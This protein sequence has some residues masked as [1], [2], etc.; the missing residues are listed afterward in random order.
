MK[1][2]TD[3]KAIDERINRMR[4]HGLTQLTRRDR[5]MEHRIDMRLAPEIIHRRCIQCIVVGSMNNGLGWYSCLFGKIGRAH[6]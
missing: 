3:G 6:V 1:Y 4:H 5:S 2:V